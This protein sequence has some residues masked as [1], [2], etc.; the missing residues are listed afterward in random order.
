[1]F[2]TLRTLARGASARAEE[3]VRDEYAIE[4]IDQK[5]R[6]AEA[7]Q[8]SAKV[9]L[10]GLIQR[11]RSEQRQLDALNSRMID[12]T[13]R[14]KE[15]LAAEQEELALEAAEAIAQMENEATVRKESLAGLDKQIIRL[16]SNVEKTHRRIVDLKQGAMLARSTRH[17]QKVQVR[18]SRASGTA[19]LQEAEDLVAS[20]LNKADPVEHSDIMDDLNAGLEPTGITDRLAAEGFGDPTKTTA[21]DVLARL[22]K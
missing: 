12:L 20:V 7:A 4:L 9:A 18:L 21:N 22:K 2:N 6:E 14:A 1:M 8:K 11:Q 15:A 13:N 3:A 17:S 16:R 10:A 5:L 19:P